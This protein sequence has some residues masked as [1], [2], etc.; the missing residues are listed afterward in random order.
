M[1]M[2]VLGV[3][4]CLREENLVLKLQMSS[5]GL[6]DMGQDTRCVW[7]TRTIISLQHLPFVLW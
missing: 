6:R 3:G 2:Q 1:E 5:G 7:Y 4:S